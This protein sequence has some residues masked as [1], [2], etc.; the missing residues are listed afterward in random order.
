MRGYR[1]SGVAP[2]RARAASDRCIS[3]SWFLFVAALVAGWPFS[4]SATCGAAV[5]ALN[6]AWEAQ[7]VTTDPGLRLDLRFEYIDQDQPRAGRRKVAVG[8]IPQHHD[9]IRTINRNWIATL[10]Y[11]PNAD[12][13]VSL[14]L[15]LLSRDHA[16]IHHN[17]GTPPTPEL[18]SARFDEIGDVRLLARRRLAAGEVTHGVIGGLKLPTGKTD[19]ELDQGGE[20]ER[21]LQP[22]TGTTD[23]IVGYYANTLRILGDAPAR[24]FAQAQI[25]A[26]LDEA[27]GYRPG[28]QYNLDLG[29]V[30]PAAGTWSGLLQVNAQVRGRER[31]ENAESENSGGSFVWL[32]PG[33]SYALGRSTQL[34]A[35]VQ[36]PVYQ[37]VNGVQLTADYAAA[38]GVHWRF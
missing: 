30:Y 5:C 10:D 32:S 36:L 14:Q 2:A 22:G 38:A 23:L 18:Q 3:N 26:A 7:G 25:Q 31:G 34:Y 1:S 27:R 4:A 28:T 24:L 15:P 11:A 17:H 6:T 9:E 37:R 35:F 20:A 21:S 19:V 13:G 8:E 29:I 12:W 16:H 33:V